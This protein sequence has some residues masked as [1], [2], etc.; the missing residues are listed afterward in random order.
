MIKFKVRP[1]DGG[2][3]YE[4]EGT[5]RD[6][7]NWERTTKG[8]SFGKLEENMHIADLYKIAWFAARRASMFS[9]VLADFEEQHDLDIVRGEADDGGED[10]EPDPTQWD[11]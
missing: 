8:A 11:R 9:G 6:I 1:V 7:L 10:S 5:T 4:V 3:P 2:E